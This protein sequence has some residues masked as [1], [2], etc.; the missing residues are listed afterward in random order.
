M[1][2]NGKLKVNEKAP[3]PIADTYHFKYLNVYFFYLEQNSSVLNLIMLI[4]K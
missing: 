1:W 2:V 4:I 3:N